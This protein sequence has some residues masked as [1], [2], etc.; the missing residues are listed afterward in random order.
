MIVSG[1]IV[2]DCIVG[3]VVSSCALTLIINNRNKTK[4]IKTEIEFYIDHVNKLLNGEGRGVLFE[5]YS[6]TYLEIEEVSFLK[7]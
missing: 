5:E 1:E 7:I 4:Y 2:N 6:D 3:G